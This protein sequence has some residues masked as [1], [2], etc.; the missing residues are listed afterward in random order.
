M[1]NP[2]SD[3][4]GVVSAGGLLDRIVSAKAARLREAKARIPLDRLM[5]L[6]QHAHSRPS[7][8]RALSS[9]DTINIIAEL[10]RQ[11]PSKGII[12][13]D[14]EPAALARSYE[15]GGAAALSVLTEEDF[16]G[17]SLAYLQ[18][19]R[20]VVDLPLLRKDF[21][22]DEYQVHEAAVA[23]ADGILL[24]VAMLDDELLRRM[25][26]TAVTIG[27]DALVEVHTAEEM[28][29][30]LKAGARIVGVNNRDLTTFTVDLT[31]SLRLARMAGDETLLVSESG[32]R[33]GDDIRALAESG[34]R[35]FLVGEQLMKAADPG[36]ALASLIAN[37]TAADMART[38]NDGERGF[39][40]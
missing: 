22:F 36:A 1:A 24:I 16:F 39:A 13:Q 32:I 38:A 21:L 12:R 2:E 15:K 6:S 28:D 9:L 25:L 17:G 27:L 7:L 35:A 11:S 29:R 3:L 26:E 34:F 5:P 10:K 4:R 8:F 23:G 31:T 19:V 18:E 37:S 20:R 14:F 30:A 33:S 40:L